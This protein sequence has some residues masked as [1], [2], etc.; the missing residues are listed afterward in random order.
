MFGRSWVRFLS[1]TQIFLCPMLVSSFTFITE[2]KIHYLY[3]LIIN[4]FVPGTQF[5][6]SVRICSLYLKKMREL[7]A[8]DFQERSNLSKRVQ[9]NLSKRVQSNQSNHARAKVELDTFKSRMTR[10]VLTVY[11]P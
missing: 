4:V 11:L 3:S 6:I 10:V 7:I 5:I 1:G 9:S 8:S 2:H